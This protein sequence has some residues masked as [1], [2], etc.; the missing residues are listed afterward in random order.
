VHIHKA[1]LLYQ[2]VHF[3]QAPTVCNT[4]YSVSVLLCV[5]GAFSQSCLTLSGGTFHAGSKCLQHLL[6]KVCA[7]V[8]V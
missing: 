8:C 2:M 7:V 5:T 4:C 1:A 3:M 6:L